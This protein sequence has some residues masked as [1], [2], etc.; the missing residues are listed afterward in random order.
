[1]KYYFLFCFMIFCAM[2]LPVFGQVEIDLPFTD[3]QKSFFDVL[4]ENLC[5]GYFVLIIIGGEFV[6][7]I[8]INIPTFIKIGIFGL[9][10]GLLAYLFTP[11][12]NGFHLFFTFSFAVVCYEFVLSQV[13]KYLKKFNV[14]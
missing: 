4:K 9:V 8:N 12:R 3:I 6:K 11:C 13:Y 5:I 10:S 7:K 14:L 2:I 1:M